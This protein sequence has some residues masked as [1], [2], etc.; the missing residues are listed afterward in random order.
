MDRR[1]GVAVNTGIEVALDDTTGS[2]MHDPGALHDL[3]A[4]RTNTQ[5]PVGEW[6]HMTITVSGPKI[7]VVLN[8]TELSTINLDEWSTPGKRRTVRN[9]SFRTSRSASCL[10]MVTLVSRT[11]AAIAGSRTSSSR[12][13]HPPTLCPDPQPTTRPGPHQEPR[14]RGFPHRFER[15]W[16]RSRQLLPSPQEVG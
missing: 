2:G 8:G 3:V 14:P 16:V 1:K 13:L 9:T 12:N 10:A 15:E 7:S 6:N 5:K 4:A 11:T